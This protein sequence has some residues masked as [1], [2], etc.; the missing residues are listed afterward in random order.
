M[1]TPFEKDNIN[2]YCVVYLCTARVTIQRNCNDTTHKPSFYGCM[3]HFW[4]DDGAKVSIK[5]TR[6]QSIFES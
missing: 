4:I 3:A 6:L 1:K 2:I 5:V